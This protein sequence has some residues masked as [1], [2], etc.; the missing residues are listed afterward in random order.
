MKKFKKHALKSAIAA[1]LA[2]GFSSAAFTQPVAG[3]V[4]HAPGIGDVLAVGLIGDGGLVDVNVAGSRFALTPDAN[5]VAGLPSMLSDLQNGTGL[6]LADLAGFVG[7]L[8]AAPLPGLPNDPSDLLS[9]LPTDGGIPSLPVDPVAT[10]FS[11]VSGG[12][13]PSL[14]GLPVDP[15]GTLTGLIPSGG[16]PSLPGLPVDVVGT[17]TGALPLDAL[18]LP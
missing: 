2:A 10:V 15:V 8:P 17:L 3:I 16:A 14:P 11:V 5:P 13:A 7:E 6:P 18:P 4:L 9:L 1:T 12:G